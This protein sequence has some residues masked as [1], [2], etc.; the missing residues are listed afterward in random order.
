MSSKIGSLDN[1]DHK[2]GGGDKKIESQKLKFAAQSKIGSKE[3]IKHK[4][5]GGEIKVRFPPVVLV[6]DIVLRPR[7]TIVIYC[8]G[9][10]LILL[11]KCLSFF[12]YAYTSLKRLL[13]SAVISY[14]Y[15]FLYLHCSFL[16]IL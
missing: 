4:P 15:H 9:L 14:D 13:L 7:V 10:V 8:Y 6:S 5:G 2:P 16:L 1:K 12:P 11:L 3:N